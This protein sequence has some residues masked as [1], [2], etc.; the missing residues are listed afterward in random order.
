MLL[1]RP[2]CKIKLGYEFCYL[3]AAIAPES[4]KLIALLLPDTTK[5]CFQLFIDYFQHCIRK[6]YG[7]TARV[8][9]IIDKA[10]AH[11]SSIVKDAR[12]TLEY[13]PTTCPE[14][15][16]VERLFEELRKGLSSRIF[17]NLDALEAHLCKVL[18]N[19]FQ[20]NAAICQL[21]NYPYLCNT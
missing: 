6:C 21:C 3:C 15:N 11:Q 16:P 17:T 10:G 7:E 9:L 1:I 20:N 18:Q 19:Y 4:G 8:L 5:H 13:L 2:T 14:L 12:L